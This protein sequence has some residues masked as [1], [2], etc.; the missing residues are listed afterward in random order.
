[1]K[2]L[3]AKAI[4]TVETGAGPEAGFPPTTRMRMLELIG[5]ACNRFSMARLT[6][7][8]YRSLGSA[9]DRSK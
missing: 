6:S 7:S 8:S 3:S 9:N 1:V 2:R 4:V 5:Q